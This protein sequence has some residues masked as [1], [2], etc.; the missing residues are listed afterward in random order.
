MIEFRP[1]THVANARLRLHALIALRFPRVVRSLAAFSY[2]VSPQ[3]KLSIDSK[4]RCFRVGRG[5]SVAVPLSRLITRHVPE[6]VGAHLTHAFAAHSL[7]FPSACSLTDLLDDSI[8][9]CN[10]ARVGRA[11]RSA[12]SAG[13]RAATP[14]AASE[15][16][17]RIDVLLMLLAGNAVSARYGDAARTLELVHATG[18]DARGKAVWVGE[19]LDRL[20]WNI[21][22]DLATSVLESVL[23]R[24]TGASA[25]ERFAARSRVA[26]ALGDA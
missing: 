20:G 21:A 8:T 6:V 5:A 24:I 18:T 25:R 7:N 3:T 1:G 9:V 19:I 10:L 11:V 26:E 15:A 17:D 23:P 16:A 13:G 2:G 12:I 22:P 4:R 14:A